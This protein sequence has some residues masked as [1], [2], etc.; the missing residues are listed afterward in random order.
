M[1]QL[2]IWML[3]GQRYALPL[4]VVESA[5]RAIEVTQ[6]PG[7]PD[8]VDG[9]VNVRGRVIPVVSMRSRF[10]LPRRAVALSDQLL[11]A[12]T[13]RRLAGF[14]VDAVDGIL[15]YEKETVALTDPLAP[16]GCIS[17]V[18]RLDD[19]LILIHDLDRLL[20]LDEEEALDGALSSAG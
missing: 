4:S 18:I 15:D 1:A 6:L 20:T 16:A 10:N 14:F 3:D 11:I 12:R 13:P 9:I 2:V 7:A 8:I 19:G 17:G 5:V